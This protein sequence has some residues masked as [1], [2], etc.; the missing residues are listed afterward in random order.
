MKYKLKFKDSVSGAQAFLAYPPLE[1]TA[2]E[3]LAR[4]RNNACQLQETLVVPCD[5][6]GNEI[7]V[8]N[9]I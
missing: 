3:A 5:E 2:A 6:D 7:E 4:H 1:K 9:Q 8:K